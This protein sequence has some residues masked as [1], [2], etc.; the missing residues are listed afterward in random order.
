M[1][2]FVIMLLFAGPLLFFPAQSNAETKYVDTIDYAL[3]QPFAGEDRITSSSQYINAV[4]RFALGIVGI[5]AVVLIMFGGLRW[6]SAAGNESIVT[7]AKEIVTSAVIGLVIAL[8]SYVILAFINPKILNFGFSP[9]KID[10]N[11]NGT[12]FWKIDWCNA[13]GFKDEQCSVDGA[14]VACN[15][16]ACTQKGFLDGAFCRGAVCAAAS[17]GSARTCYADPGSPKTAAKCQ[18]KSC[19]DQVSRCWKF[20]DD[21]DNFGICL[22]GYYDT[23]VVSKLHYTVLTTGN[24]NDLQETTYRSLCEEK[25]PQETEAVTIGANPSV[26]GYTGAAGDITGIGWNCG[27]SCE[28][29]EEVQSAAGQGGGGSWTE[30]TCI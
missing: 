25:T 29:K 4:Y 27:F 3:E 14:D 8:L 1:K 20:I 28:V 16:V 22:C 5:I 23:L 19:S 7:E 11:D 10:I 2:K 13:G 26:F 17:D 12:D 18:P 30:L 24:L 6:M 9:A 15:D 21:P